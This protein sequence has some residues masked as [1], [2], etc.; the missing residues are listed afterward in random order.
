MAEKKIPRVDVKFLVA[1]NETIHLLSSQIEFP[2][3]HLT[4]KG[5]GSL[6]F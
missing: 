6:E 2:I 4:T 5:G 1:F 3:P